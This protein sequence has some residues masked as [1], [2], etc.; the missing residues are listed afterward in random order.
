MVKRV[1]LIDVHDRHSVLK[2]V[3][4]L[5]QYVILLLFALRK[6][7]RC[8]LHRCNVCAYNWRHVILL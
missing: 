6:R 7:L 1:E 3:Q 8:A 2:V 5:L 4:Q